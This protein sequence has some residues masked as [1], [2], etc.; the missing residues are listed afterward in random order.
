MQAPQDTKPRW[1][2]RKDARPQ[3]LLAAALEQFVRRYGAA[4]V[5]I[6]ETQVLLD[7]LGRTHPALVREVVPRL[8]APALL[9]DVLQR[10]LDEGVSL[11]NLKD[12]LGALA[13]WAPLEK[14]PVALTEHVRSALRRSI[15]FGRATPT[16]VLGA[17]RLD[18]MI[19][20]AV[21]GAIHKTA[22]GSLL[23]LEPPL[24]RDI[25]S[26]VGRAVVRQAREGVSPLPILLTSADIRR[27][28][29]RL[30]EAEHPELAVLSYAEVAPEA[31]VEDLGTIRV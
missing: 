2:R 3:E 20:D 29:R 19:E 24:A 12:I 8:V 11:R 27:Y 23:A 4:L 15:T 28:V 26:A 10:L 21:R 22:A 5:G 18:P 17:Y 6:Q 13:V 14:D 30:I 31:R 9:A 25:V 1:E 16:G 7:Q